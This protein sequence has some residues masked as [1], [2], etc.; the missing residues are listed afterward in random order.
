MPASVKAELR[1]TMKDLGVKPPVDDLLVFL[2]KD[3][4][5]P[6]LENSVILLLKDLFQTALIADDLSPPRQRS[7]FTG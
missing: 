1:S 3:E 7:T 4:Y 5:S 6:D 2:L